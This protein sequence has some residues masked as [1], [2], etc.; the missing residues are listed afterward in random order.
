MPSHQLNKRGVEKLCDPGRY[1]DGS[2]LYLVVTPTLR[3]Q[4][5]AR[6][7]IYGQQTDLGLGSFPETSLDEARDECARLRKIARQG[8]DP[9]VERRKETISFEEATKRVLGNLRPTWRSAGHA[10]RWLSSIERYAYPTLRDRPIYT[11]GTSEILN[12][13]T[14]IWTEK[15]DTANRIKQRLATIFDWAKGA[16]HYPHENPVNG[17]K[18]ALPTVK[19]RAEHMPA[20]PW[21]ELPA[22]MQDL[23]QRKG[24]SARCLEFIILTAA[25]SMESARRN[26]G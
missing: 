7:T 22:F 26:M 15:H 5:V 23:A 16:G 2:C 17:L 10:D 24:M 8:G 21:Q 14:P 20:L 12:V 1:S 18:K 19:R 3:K 11:I 25:R 4:F 6:L 9:R 13:L